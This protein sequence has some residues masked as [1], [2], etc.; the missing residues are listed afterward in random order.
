MHFVRSNPRI[1]IH[2]R[3]P[4]IVVQ[5][6]NPQTVWIPDLS[7][8]HNIFFVKNIWFGLEPGCIHPMHALGTADAWCLSAGRL[9][10][11]AQSFE[12]LTAWCSCTAT[13][14]P[15]VH[16]YCAEYVCTHSQ[17]LPVYIPPAW[18][19]CVAV[20]W[21]KRLA[22]SA[23]HY[24]YSNKHFASKFIPNKDDSNAGSACRSGLS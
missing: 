6:V 11:R 17:S 19:M 23:V 18:Q 7:L 20:Q 13:R 10:I 4:Q 16:R 2:A 9:T 3:N 12:L 14:Y 5:S 1:P 22:N 24:T 21:S 8:V 15:C